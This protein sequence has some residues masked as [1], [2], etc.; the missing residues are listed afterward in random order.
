MLSC[1]IQTRDA[2]TGHDFV[3]AILNMGGSNG[4]GD[5][6]ITTWQSDLFVV[7]PINCNNTI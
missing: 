4:D 6:T 5:N 2:A 3:D 1:I 7:L